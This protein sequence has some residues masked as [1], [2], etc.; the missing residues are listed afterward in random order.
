MST[1]KHAL[2]RYE[3]LDR[4]FSNKG[5]KFFIDDLITYGVA[6]FEQTIS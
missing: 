3:T 2:I 4:C 6:T 5:R 1:N